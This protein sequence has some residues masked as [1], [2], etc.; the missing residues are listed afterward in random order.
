MAKNIPK[1]NPDPAQYF[2]NVAVLTAGD[3]MVAVHR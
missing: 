3:D 1:T 2:F